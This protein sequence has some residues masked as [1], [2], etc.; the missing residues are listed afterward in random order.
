VLLH[1]CR[2]CGKEDPNRIAADDNPV[3]IMRMLLLSAPGPEPD[4]VAEQESA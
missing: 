3:L 1:R 4:V 2:S